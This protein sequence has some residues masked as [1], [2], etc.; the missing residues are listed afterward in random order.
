MYRYPTVDLISLLNNWFLLII[1]YNVIKNG[2]RIPHTN[3]EGNA[4]TNSI[5]AWFPENQTSDKSL[6][7]IKYSVYISSIKH[8]NANFKNIWMDK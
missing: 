3:R 7:K 5:I 1:K 6:F 4:N 8:F 2:N